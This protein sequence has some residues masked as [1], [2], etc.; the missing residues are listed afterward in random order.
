MQLSITEQLHALMAEWSAAHRERGWKPFIA[1]GVVNEASYEGSAPRI[2]FFLKEAY[3]KD[4][5]GDRSLTAWLADGAMTRMWGTVAEWTYGISRTTGSC[6]PPK[7]RL[8]PAEKSAL[9]QRISVVNVKKSNGSA[10][11]DY[12]ELLRCTVADQVFLRRE[13]DILKPDVIICGNNSS[14]LRL[15]YGATLRENGKVSEDGGIP[16]P[17][18]REHGYAVVGE[19]IILDYYHPANQYPS[20]MNYYTV[21]SLYQQALRA[22][23]GARDVL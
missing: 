6:I 21:C 23:E 9:L 15:L 5:G 18:L 17:F 2:C 14:L 3:A 11:S 10:R 4:D 22:K 8:N 1:D 7:P 19:Q 20:I 12:K 13:L 16:G